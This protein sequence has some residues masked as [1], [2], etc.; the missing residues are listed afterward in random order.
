MVAQSGPE[1]E[2]QRVVGSSPGVDENLGGVLVAGGSP[3]TPKCCRS[4]LGQ[5][6]KP[7]NAHIG[8]GMSCLHLNVVGSGS[9][10]SCDPK[11]EEHV[12]DLLGFF[13]LSTTEGLDDFIEDNKLV[14]RVLGH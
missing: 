2:K 6:N 3:R 9:S 14:Y 5:D 1:A 7:P 13:D 11:T 8:P 10:T 12:C 4:T